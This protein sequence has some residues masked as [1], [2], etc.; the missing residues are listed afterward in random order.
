MGTR[1]HAASTVHVTPDEA[2]RLARIALRCGRVVAS[3]YAKRATDFSPGDIY[4]AASEGAYDAVSNF[5]PGTVGKN[6]KECSFKTF[7]NA[8]VRTAIRRFLK[9]EM[10]RR[11]Y[12]KNA[13]DASAHSMEGTAD[14]VESAGDPHQYPPEREAAILEAMA[15]VKRHLRPDEWDLLF[16]RFAEGRTC[17]EI[18][19]LHGVTAQAINLRVA[20]LVERCMSQAGWKFS[21]D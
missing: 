10:I 11:K 13:T 17:R 21:C 12:V 3:S 2:N 7:A 8:C 20:G 5:R 4:W 6:G 15:V 19:A 16:R 9:R 1:T 14:I 18:S